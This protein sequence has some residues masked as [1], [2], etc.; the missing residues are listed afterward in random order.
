MVAHHSNHLN[1]TLTHFGV[2]SKVGWK[3]EAVK[4]QDAEI[5]LKQSS[6]K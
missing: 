2:E 5:S 4:L 1:M 6:E 3:A